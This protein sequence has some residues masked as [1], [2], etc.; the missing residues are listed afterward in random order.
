M[1]TE[2]RIG[3]QHSAL[4]IEKRVALG[5][6]ACALTALVY[7]TTLDHPFVFDDRITV[8]L[9]PSLVDLSDLR[10]I[11]LYNLAHPVVNVSYAIDSAFSGV[12]SFGFHVT[13]GILHLVVVALF[14]GWCMRPPADGLRPGSDL[15]HTSGEPTSDPGL[16]PAFQWPAFFAA[17]ALCLLPGFV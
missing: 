7:Q 17:A 16:T 6:L 8:L 11:L 5:I 13:N 14:Y 4:V 2:S 10:G 9:N 12:S 3:I 15:R 1:P